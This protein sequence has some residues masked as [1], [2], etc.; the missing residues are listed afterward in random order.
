MLRPA[1]EPVP[2]WAWKL[3]DAAVAACP[4]LACRPIPDQLIVNEYKP[5]QGIGAHTDHV[6]LFGDYVLGISLGSG[7]VMQ[8]Q[9]RASGRTEDVWLAPG[10]AYKMT[11]PARYAIAARKNDIHPVTGAKVARRD[12][13]SVTF[14]CAAKK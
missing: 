12:R 3:Y 13:V 5:G 10:S 6:R 9:E 14:R 2:A 1:P 8:F 4:D 7:A 11:G